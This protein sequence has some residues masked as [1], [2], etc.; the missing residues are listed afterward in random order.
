VQNGSGRQTTDAH[1]GEFASLVS[2]KSSCAIQSFQDCLPSASR[3]ASRTPLGRDLFERLGNVDQFCTQPNRRSSSSRIS[4]ACDLGCTLH[5]SSSVISMQSCPRCTNGRCSSWLQN[6]H[7]PSRRW[8]WS[9]ESVTWISGPLPE[10]DFE[11]ELL[12]LRQEDSWRRETGRSSPRHISRLPNRSNSDEERHMNA[13]AQ[14]RGEGL[15]STVGR[16]RLC[17][18]G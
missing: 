17:P 18:F 13:P 2:I 4:P 3:V 15:R 16:A 11:R 8:H 5:T 12:Q 10:I 6:L 7:L 14:S 1:N 9:I